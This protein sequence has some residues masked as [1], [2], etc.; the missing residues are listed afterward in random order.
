MLC[1]KENS[2]G[3]LVIRYDGDDKFYAFDY[4]EFEEGL[5]ELIPLEP[6]YAIGKIII[7]RFNDEEEIDEWWEKGRIV[8]IKDG[9]YTVDYF[10]G[11]LSSIVIDGEDCSDTLCIELED[12]YNNNDI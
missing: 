4:W 6:E 1:E 11:D 12:D 7:Q 2:E 5:V 10:K 9:F 3:E 8:S